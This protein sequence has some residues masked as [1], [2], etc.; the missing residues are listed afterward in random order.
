MSLHTY[1]WTASIVAG[2]CWLIAA[3][4]AVRGMVTDLKDRGSSQ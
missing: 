1:L 4:V 2:P 3:T